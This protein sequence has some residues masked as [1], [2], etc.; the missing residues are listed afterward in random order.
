MLACIAC[1]A[2]EGGEDGSRAAATPHGGKSLTS[3]V[4]TNLATMQGCGTTRYGCWA[5]GK[6]T[7]EE[8]S[9]DIEGCARFPPRCPLGSAVSTA[10]HAM[11]SSVDLNAP[12]CPSAAAS[13]IGCCASCPA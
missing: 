5:C 4:K 10:Y 1:S 6:Q 13:L 2:K 12:P 9:S 3:Q 7:S 11:H 8:N